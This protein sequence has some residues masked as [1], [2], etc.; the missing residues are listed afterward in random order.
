[1]N[2]GSSK[3]WG[4]LTC[5]HGVLPSIKKIGFIVGGKKNHNSIMLQKIYI[6]VLIYLYKIQKEV[7]SSLPSVG[8]ENYKILL[9]LILGKLQL[10]KN[11][12]SVKVAPCPPLVK[13][14]TFFFND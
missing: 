11:K 6:L 10:I 9:I 5:F 3:L 1:M 2:G 4:K 12:I 8:F 13:F 7:Y 14:M